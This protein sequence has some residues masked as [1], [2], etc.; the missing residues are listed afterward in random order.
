MHRH[1]RRVIA[2]LMGLSCSCL[3]ALAP[4][5]SVL[6]ISPADVPNPRQTNGTWV[7]DMANLL[8]AES[9]SELN[10]IIS[11]L[12]A[13]NGTEIAVV[14]V[15]DTYP[16]SSPKAFATELFNDWG[17]GK[18]EANNGVLFLVSK[19]D[20]RTELEIG[21]GLEGVITN[22]QASQLLRN[23]VTPQF[24]I[25]NFDA[26]ILQGTE[27]LV[28]ILS[29][30]QAAPIIN[31]EKNDSWARPVAMLLAVFG[32]GFIFSQLGSNDN[33]YDNNHHHHNHH[34]NNSYHSNNHNSSGGFSSGG[35]DFGGGG[36]D[37]G[38]G[39]DSW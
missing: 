5:S 32:V 12:E 7:T 22:E 26:G 19:G 21:Y 11:N 10:R 25:G 31:P 14:T 16:S 17:I 38:G 29:G 37:G 34:H 6:A 27:M 35:S 4:V 15:E 8:S 28:S 18:A 36:S 33:R 20:R 1:Y 9:E 2:F 23:E 3:L 13:E 30:E 24:K 39:G